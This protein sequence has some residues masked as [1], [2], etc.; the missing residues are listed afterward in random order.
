MRNIY[1]LLLILISSFL[2]VGC[3]KEEPITE[4]DK[5][6]RFEEISFISKSNEYNIEDG[7]INFYYE[8]NSSL[9]YVNTEEY[10]KLLDGIYLSNEFE[11]IYNSTSLT[12]NVLVEDDEKV[13]E[14]SLTIDS[15]NDTIFVTNLLFFDLYMESTETNYGEG[16]IDLEAT[17][18]AGSA[19]TYDLAKYDFD[20]LE[21][22]NEIYMPLVITNLLFNQSNYFDTYY[23]G[24]VLYGIDTSQ[25]EVSDLEEILK[26]KYN[27]N[28]IPEDI[29]IAN[30]N[31]YTFIIDYFYGL[32]AERN[33]ED[34]FTFINREDFLSG[35]NDKNIFNVTERLDD[36]HSSHLTR[37]FDNNSTQELSFMSTYQGTHI[38]AFYDVVSEVQKEAIEHFGVRLNYIDFKDYE[39]IDNNRTLIIYLLEFTVD[40]PKEVEAIIKEA[41]PDTENIVIDLAFNTG[42]NLGAVLRMFT[43]M[44]NKTIEYHYQNPLDGQ[45]I[46]G[47]VKGENEA[48]DKYN[49]FIKT[50]SI[51]F[52]AANLAAN[53]AKEL[54]IPVIGRKSSGGASSISFFVFPSG[55][56]TIM[57]SN[58]VLSNK[59]Y[60]S[61]EYGIEP[62]YILYK[63]YDSLEIVSAINQFK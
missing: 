61:I 41:H 58:T 40:T 11:F 3:L 30:Y 34:S 33:I 10:L 60:E 20:I 62:D 52:S 43:L 16:L 45:K 22:G 56:I 23:N 17:I 5:N 14:E 35:N 38:K 51:T 29:K 13:Y 46:T 18:I 24:E 63:L 44:T 21:I 57:S 53:I 26:S 12:I 27:N 7:N 9:A 37:G 19:I 32:K 48:Y 39:Y 31:F 2:L 4:I 42:G 47:R 28:E 50:S 49:Y 59:A 55:S 36:L 15:D 8:E 1:T 54:E 25:L 6:E